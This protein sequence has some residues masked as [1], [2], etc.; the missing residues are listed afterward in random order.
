MSNTSS[1]GGAG[2]ATIL[3][4]VFIV[5]KLCG[6]I[7][8]SWLWVLSPLWISTAFAI[9]VLGILMIVKRNAKRNRA[10]FAERMRQRCQR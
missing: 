1:S 8:W 5:L 2:L 6:V 9:I 7:A 4:V 3:L 10:K